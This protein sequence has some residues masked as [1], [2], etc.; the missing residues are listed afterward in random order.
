MTPYVAKWAE[1][2]EE[3]ISICLLNDLHPGNAE[4]LN[5]FGNLEDFSVILPFQMAHKNK[6]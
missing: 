1:T 4:M 2:L 3:F 6:R 5:V